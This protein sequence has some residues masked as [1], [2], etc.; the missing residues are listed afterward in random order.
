MAEGDE[1]PQ[2]AG[3]APVMT[4]AQ[5]QEY[6]ERLPGLWAAQAA[7]AGGVGPAGG[8]AM[9]QPGA[10]AAAAVGQLGPCHLGRDKMERYKKWGDWMKEAK[11][12][13]AFLGITANSQKVAYIRSCAGAELLTF[14]EKEARIRFEGIPAT[15]ATLPDNQP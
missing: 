6:M 15:G 14:C 8:A 9:V 4:L 10:G 2:P 5:F 12:K 7:A 1:P 13:M 3:P 11:S